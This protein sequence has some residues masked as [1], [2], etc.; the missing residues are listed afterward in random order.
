MPLLATS[1]GLP[2]V[3]LGLMTFGPSEA[4]G[5]R[6]TDLDTYNKVLDTFQG[7]GYTEVDTARMYVAGQ[8][9]AFTREARWKERGLTLASKVQYPNEDGAHQAH[10][11]VESVEKSLAELG[12]DTIDV[13]EPP[14]RP[15]ASPLA[16]NGSMKAAR[17]RTTAES[18]DGPKGRG[19]WVGRRE[20][21]PHGH[22][23]ELEE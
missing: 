3:I 20:T 4:D 23:Q 6:I 11:V 18:R 5:A 19:S 8:Q 17:R 2:R 15:S 7:R 13:R 10:K 12:T 21:Y 22:G 14:L 16:A 9:E 1:T